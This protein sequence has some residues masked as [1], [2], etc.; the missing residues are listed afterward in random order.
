MCFTPTTTTTTNMSGTKRT[1]ISIMD[2][3]SSTQGSPSKRI[4]LPT[5]KASHNG[6]LYLN[7][8]P[9]F[10]P[11]RPLP[12]IWPWNLMPD[13]NTDSDAAAPLPP[14]AHIASRIP[15]F[16]T[17]GSS[18]CGNHA[19]EHVFPTQAAKNKSNK[20]KRVGTLCSFCFG[21]YKQGDLHQLPCGHFTCLSCL[22]ERIRQIPVFMAVNSQQIYQATN[23]MRGIMDYLE[24]GFAE[25]DPLGEGEGLD[26]ADTVRQYWL[27]EFVKLRGQVAVLTNLSCA[28]C[29]VPIQPSQFMTCL[30][31]DLSKVVWLTEQWLENREPLNR[32]M[33]GWPDCKGF[34]PSWCSYLIKGKNEVFE[35]SEADCIKWWCPN[36]KGNCFEGE[37]GLKPS[38]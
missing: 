11:A 3:D 10:A 1:F 2:E 29:V 34:I 17:H 33:C 32:Q 7:S 21:P 27:D 31:P 22:E 4:C 14:P 24:F 13:T 12:S 38:W 6:H 26:L 16:H 23:E 20:S 8:P 28:Y 30:S 35:R 19:H 15:P 25:S 36:C 37:G 9:K 18:H 5:D